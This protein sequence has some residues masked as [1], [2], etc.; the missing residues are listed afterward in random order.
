MDGISCAAL[1]VWISGN[2]VGPVRLGHGDLARQRLHSFATQ[3]KVKSKYMQKFV[4]AS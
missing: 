4:H 3:A 2:S 1:E